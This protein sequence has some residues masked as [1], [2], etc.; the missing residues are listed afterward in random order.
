M[1]KLWETKQIV[2]YFFKK[3]KT[4]GADNKSSPLIKEKKYGPSTC[5][6]IYFKRLGMLSTQAK[7]VSLFSFFFFLSLIL[8]F[9]YID[10]CLVFLH[11]YFIG[12][13]SFYIFILF[14][15]ISFF[16]VIRDILIKK[17]LMT[18]KRKF[19]YLKMKRFK[20]FFYFISLHS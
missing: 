11:I 9:L 8:F 12:F 20:K 10:F 19:K 3:K 7:L 13:S 1:V 15:K 18:Y 16:L 14:Y 5:V 4:F 2:I 6:E 17:E